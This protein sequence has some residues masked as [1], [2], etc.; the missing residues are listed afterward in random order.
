MS[1]R[2]HEWWMARRDDL[3]HIL[4]ER[5][6]VVVYDGE[7]INDLIFDLLSIDS[8]TK[9]FYPPA[10]N[11]HPEI[12]EKAHTLGAGF[13]CVSASEVSHVFN[14]LRRYRGFQVLLFPGTGDI[15]DRDDPLETGVVPVVDP[16][17]PLDPITEH[18]RG[19]SVLAHADIPGHGAKEKTPEAWMTVLQDRLKDL[20]A[21]VKG[22]YVSGRNGLPHAGEWLRNCPHCRVLCLGR[23]GGIIL[24]PETGCPDVPGT[25][26]SLE[27]INAI[28]PD[29]ELWVEL[30]ALA[31]ERTVALLTRVEAAWDAERARVLCLDMNG[32]GAA[33]LKMSRRCR[34]MAGLSGGTGLWIPWEAVRISGYE[35]GNP[36]LRVPGDFPVEP[37]DAVLMTPLGLEGHWRALFAEHYLRAR[38]MCQV[39]M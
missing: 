36:V 23:G 38:R 19:K 33:F 37:G 2:P 34:M 9:L 32:A 20:D 16:F 31:M 7:T 11:P 25:A 35:H 8:L 17:A 26:E 30:D 28:H 21:R 3:L 6:P 12:L 14:T 4:D 27:D 13:S 1:S 39:P 22:L 24:D 15:G 5:C 18:I 29:L 10:V